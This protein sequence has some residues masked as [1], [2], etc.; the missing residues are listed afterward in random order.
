[1]DTTFLN[2]WCGVDEMFKAI[3]TSDFSSYNETFP[4]MDAELDAD[5]GDMVLTFALAGYRKDELVVTT[6]GDVVKLAGTP[7]DGKKETHLLKRGIRKR[8]FSCKYQLPAGKFDLTK[9]KASY[10]DGVLVLA[11][12]SIPDATPNVVAID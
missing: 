10:I 7:E 6:D 4:P 9:V 5:T 2:P 8:K 11:V 3:M 12:P 1:M